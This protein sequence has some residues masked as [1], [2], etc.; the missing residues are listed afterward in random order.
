MMKGLEGRTYEE[1]SLGPWV[2]SAQIIGAEEGPHGS[3][4]SSQGTEGQC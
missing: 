1:Q 3:C 2:C 4:S